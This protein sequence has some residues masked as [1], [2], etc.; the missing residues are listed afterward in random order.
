MRLRPEKPR[1]DVRAMREVES[2]F[3]VVVAI[4]EFLAQGEM[5]EVID[6]VGPYWQM[7]RLEVWYGAQKSLSQCAVVPMTSFWAFLGFAQ[8][9]WVSLLMLLMLFVL[10]A[11]ICEYNDAQK[12]G[13]VRVLQGR[14][15]LCA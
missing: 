4:C 7:N 9:S 2:E 3:L 6:L 5:V 11:A 10:V 12:I 14:R 1:D 15:P 13:R 8:L